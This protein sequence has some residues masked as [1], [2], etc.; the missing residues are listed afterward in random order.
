M[1]TQVQAKLLFEIVKK[2]INHVCCLKIVPHPFKGN[3]IFVY[4]LT[5][6]S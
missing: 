6:T 4:A 1:E 3:L 2:E 5:S